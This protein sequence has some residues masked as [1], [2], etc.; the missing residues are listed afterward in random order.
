MQRPFCVRIVGSSVERDASFHNFLEI[1]KFGFRK[2]FHREV[3]LHLIFSLIT[4]T[5]ICARWLDAHS[6][7]VGFFTCFFFL[8]ENW[9]R[10]PHLWIVMILKKKSE[11]WFITCYYCY[12]DYVT[13]VTDSIHKWPKKKRW[14]TASTCHVRCRHPDVPGEGPLIPLATLWD[15]PAAFGT[16]LDKTSAGILRK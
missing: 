7:P 16:C 9:E 4:I 14:A 11:L 5:K 2:D 15:D 1:S 3:G 12:Y 13:S 8:G 10:W 6:G